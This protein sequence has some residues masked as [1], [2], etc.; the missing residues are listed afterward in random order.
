MPPIAEVNQPLPAV[1]LGFL[2]SCAVPWPYFRDNLQEQVRSI[3]FIVAYL[4]FFQV[5][6]LSLPIVFASMIG[7]LIVAVGLMFFMEGLRPG[8]MPLGETIGAVLPRNSS[9]ALILAF[10][11]LVGLGATFAEP[12]IAALKAAVAGVRPNDAPLLY[13][14]L[15]DFSGQLVVSIGIGVSIAV[16]LSIL[17]FFYNWSLKTL[18]A[19]VV[20]TLCALTKSTK[21]V[22]S[23]SR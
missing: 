14:L 8:L 18:I 12:A 11:S 13:S 5:V 23:T 17:P 6:I 22:S 15:N 7:I 16:S 2:A 4:L 19:P 3:W 20:V 21:S 9:L 1:R 10:A